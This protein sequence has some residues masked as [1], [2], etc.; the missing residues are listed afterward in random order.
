M[1]SYSIRFYA[2]AAVNHVAG[3]TGS[4]KRM[5]CIIALL[6]HF[7]VSGADSD[8]CASLEVKIC[9]CIHHQRDPLTTHMTYTSR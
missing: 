1:M 3:V 8:F 4:S 6:W 2:A 5:L 9:T 7:A